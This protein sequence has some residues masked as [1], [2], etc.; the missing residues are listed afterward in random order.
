MPSETVQEERPALKVEDPD[1]LARAAGSLI[2]AVK[3]EQNPKFQNSAFL[4]LMKQLRDRE[5]VVEG[6][7]M[8]PK[9]EA[10]TTASSWVADFQSSVPAADVKGKGRAVEIF[11]H[12]IT[13]SMLPEAPH[14]QADYHQPVSTS[15]PP[16]SDDKVRESSSLPAADEIDEYFR[17]E[18]DAYVEYWRGPAPAQNVAPRTADWDRLQRDWDNFE[19]TATGIRLMSNY[20]FQANNPYLLGETSRHHM[21]HS[22]ERH[23]LYDVSL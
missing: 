5:V 8:V 15:A 14:M 21:M 22:Q 17:Q 19:A 3:H 13:S 12:P 16:V 18:N 11:E 1:E 9:E 10:A 7:Q 23:T 20:Q 4:G 6:N 2:D